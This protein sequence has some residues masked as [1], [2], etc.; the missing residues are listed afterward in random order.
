MGVAEL[1]AALGSIATDILTS[2]KG[3]SDKSVDSTLKL[4]LAGDQKAIS[5]LEAASEITAAQANVLRKSATNKQID[6]ILK[7]TKKLDKTSG[8][9]NQ[10]EKAGNFD[11]AKKDFYSLNPTNIQDRGNDVITGQLADGRNVIVRPDSR[12]GKATLEIQNTPNNYTKVRY[13]E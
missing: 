5:N 1:S 8:R 13:G 4:A 3:R 6:D 2:G 9:A 10:F 11:S 7:N 12:S